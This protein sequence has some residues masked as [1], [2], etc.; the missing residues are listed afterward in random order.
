MDRAEEDRRV[1]ER[2]RSSLSEEDRATLARMDPSL[3]EAYGDDLGRMDDG[4]WKEHR[5]AMAR[6]Q[7]EDRIAKPLAAELFEGAFIPWE[8]RERL[9]G[10]AWDQLR[11]ALY[12][13]G[14][15]L[16]PA[17]PVDR[18]TDHWVVKVQRRPT[19]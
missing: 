19:S 8:L 3:L 12:W 16:E 4:Q 2:V 11:K 9:W 10:P 7:E 17:A 13:R 1:E 6:V 14:L 15:R 18:W 5:E